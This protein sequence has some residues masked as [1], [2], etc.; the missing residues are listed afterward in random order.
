MEHCFHQFDPCILQPPPH[1]YCIVEMH[2]LD[3]A[4]AVRFVNRAIE[5]PVAEILAMVVTNDLCDY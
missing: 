2:S 5:L 4:D 3:V 1:S